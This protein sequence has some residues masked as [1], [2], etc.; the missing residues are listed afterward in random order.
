[1]D[2][3][4]LSSLALAHIETEANRMWP[5][6]TGGILLGYLDTNDELVIRFAS[7]PGPNAIHRRTTYT[8]DHEAQMEYLD[9]MYA[10]YESVAD[11]VGDW[12]THP[13]MSPVMSF[14]DC[15][16]LCRIAHSPSLTMKNPVMVIA[17]N[18][19]SQ[20]WDLRSYVHK[21]HNW[22]QLLD[23]YQMPEIHIFEP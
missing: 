3:I 4:W 2:R 9:A 13:G 7:G 6:E 21:E 18:G 23:I 16:T 11:Y 20:L 19:N 17:G 14:L 8:P 5:L 15:R 10:E 12:H 1:M 22:W